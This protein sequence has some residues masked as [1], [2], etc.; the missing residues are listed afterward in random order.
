MPGAATKIRALLKEHV[1]E[2]TLSQIRGITGLES[3]EASMVM[4]YLMRQRYLSRRKVKSTLPGPKSVW[5]Y[6]YHRVRMA[7]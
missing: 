7:P 3:H 4:S 6:T 1:G 2:I 5:S